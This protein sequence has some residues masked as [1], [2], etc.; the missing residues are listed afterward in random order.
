MSQPGRQDFSDKVH[1]KVK[2]DSQKTFTE[3]Y[4]D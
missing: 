3:Q 2:P 4:V 1:D